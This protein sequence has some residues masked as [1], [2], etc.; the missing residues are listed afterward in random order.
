MSKQSSRLGSNVHDIGQSSRALG[1]MSRINS[2]TSLTSKASG[3][4]RKDVAD[5]TYD[6]KMRELNERR[7][8]AA[9]LQSQMFG[10]KQRLQESAITMGQIGK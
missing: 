7:P 3:V 6:A 8:A 2:S 9:S 5:S 4:V 10:S 1:G